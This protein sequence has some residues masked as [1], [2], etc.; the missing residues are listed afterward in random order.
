MPFESVICR[1]KLDEERGNPW[2]CGCPFCNEERLEIEG[3]ARADMDARIQLVCGSHFFNQ[4]VIT[5]AS[6][7]M[8]VITAP[9][10]PP[11]S[12]AKIVE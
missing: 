6:S 10:T 12:A 7:G 8:L 4:L 3:E 2:I 9:T 5:E 1:K 11:T